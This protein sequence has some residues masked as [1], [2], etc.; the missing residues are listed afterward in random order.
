MVS[1][2]WDR[3]SCGLAI[4]S[5]QCYAYDEE[6]FGYLLRVQ[7]KRS[8]R[9]ARPFRLLLVDLKEQP[10]HPIRI[11]SR[12]ARV[13]LAGLWRALREDDIIG[14]YDT[15]CVAGALLAECGDDSPAESSEVIVHRV[16]EVLGAS[17]PP[18]IAARLQVRVCQIQ[19]R[20]TS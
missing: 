17:L 14:W 10:G 13:L 4:E 1:D 11:E 12:V 16:T 2:I 8:E 9:A 5:S 7:R 19:P 15:S 20:L 18:D 3:C 6:A